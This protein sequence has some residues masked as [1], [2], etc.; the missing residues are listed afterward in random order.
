[1]VPDRLHALVVQLMDSHSGSYACPCIYLQQTLSHVPEERQ[2][3]RWKW[4]AVNRR[5]NA[6]VQGFVQQ[7]VDEAT[8]RPAPDVRGGCDCG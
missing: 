6:A 3:W 1:M 8:L 4:R 2:G 7:G 5:C